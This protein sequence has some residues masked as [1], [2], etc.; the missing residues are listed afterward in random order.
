LPVSRFD[1]VLV[2]TFAGFIAPGLRQGPFGLRAP[3]REAAGCSLMLGLTPFGSLARGTEVEEVAHA[4]LG[5]NQMCGG[6]E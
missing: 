6:L 4:K 5:G 2:E 3:V 1:P